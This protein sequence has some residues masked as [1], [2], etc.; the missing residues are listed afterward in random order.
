LKYFAEQRFGQ[1]AGCT[2][3]KVD[4][5]YGFTAQ[6][7]AP[8]DGFSAN[9]IDHGIHLLQGS[10]EV[11]VAVVTSL[12]AKWDMDIDTRHVTIQF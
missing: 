11:K 8:D 2:A 5:M 7:I 4:G 9:G 6:K 12:S 10:R 3:T 1:Q